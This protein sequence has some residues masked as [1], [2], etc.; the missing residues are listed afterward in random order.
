MSEQDYLN[1]IYYRMKDVLIILLN[2]EKSLNGIM[3]DLGTHP[4][5]TDMSALTDLSGLME[6]I[7][8]AFS[9]LQYAQRET[10]DRIYEIKK[11]ERCY[12]TE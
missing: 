2:C 8:E 11:Y 3:K 5:A 9:D 4:S 12:E 1:Y 7:G 6:M 10:Y